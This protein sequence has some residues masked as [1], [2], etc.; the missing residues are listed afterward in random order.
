MT[1]DPNEAG[2]YQQSVV[3]AA[4]EFIKSN[5][6]NDSWTMHQLFVARP[7][8]DNRR[9]VAMEFG[10][11]NLYG[12]VTRAYAM[13]H[14]ATRQSFYRAIRGRPWFG[15]P[16]GKIFKLHILLW[17]WHAQIDEK[18]QC[19]PAVLSSP[20]LKIP[21]CPG[22]LN[23]FYNPEELHQL[24]EPERPICL[25]P[26]SATFPTL[27]AIVLTNDTVITIQI[28]I[29]SK[30]DTKR[31]EFDRVYKN[32]PPGL[33]TKRSHRCHVFI[34]DGDVNEKLL[35]EQTLTEIPKEIH[36][37][38]ALVDVEELDSMVPVTEERLEALEKA[39]LESK[40]V[41]KLAICDLV[42][43][44]S[45]PGISTGSDGYKGWLLG[46]WE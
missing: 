2:T 37:Y 17:F 8:P 20:Q 6:F 46:S 26:T 19:T 41:L 35:R 7:T 12:F 23:F 34:T 5:R 11:N 10:T 27:D 28:T 29:A 40:Y 42:F 18:L 45:F 36:V 43:I 22:N 24:N 3:S 33:L 32:L 9:Q 15:S 38:S 30:H 25:V 13:H 14:H 39:R 21:A 44:G 4:Y 16:A 31:I 1:K